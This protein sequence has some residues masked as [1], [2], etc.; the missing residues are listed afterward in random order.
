MAQ[1]TMVPPS[2]D[3][4]LADEPCRHHWVIQPA[5]GP[6]SLGACQLCGEAREFKNYVESASWGDSRLAGRSGSDAP[7]QVTRNVVNTLDDEEE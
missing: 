5:S 6:V 7:A 4:P 1:Q 2:G 3:P